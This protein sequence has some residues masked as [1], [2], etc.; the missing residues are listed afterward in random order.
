M[1]D[2]VC[3]EAISAGVPATTVQNPAALVRCYR[4]VEQRQVGDVVGNGRRRVRP[5]PTAMPAGLR[6]GSVTRARRPRRRTVAARRSGRRR[7]HKPPRGARRSGATVIRLT[8]SGSPIVTICHSD[9]KQTGPWLRPSPSANPRRK[10]D[11]RV[12]P[13]HR[14]WVSAAGVAL[15][16]GRTTGIAIPLPRIT[17]TAVGSLNVFRTLCLLNE[18]RRKFRRSHHPAIRCGRSPGR[19]EGPVGLSEQVEGTGD[20]DED[21]A[22]SLT[23]RRRTPRANIFSPHGRRGGGRVR[24]SDR[25]SY[26]TSIP[27]SG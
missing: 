6:D 14:P 2:F 15:R 5:L 10:S 26:P 12:C 21:A 18:D 17:S 24:N 9:Q 8:I 4:L 16:S 19:K 7:I 3:R 23:T 22:S 13:S 25:S 20:P 27:P 11:A 1:L